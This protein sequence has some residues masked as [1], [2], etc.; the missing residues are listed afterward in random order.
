M[1][2][3]RTADGGPQAERR[4][5]DQLTDWPD[6]RG[7]AEDEL[8]RALDF[9]EVTWVDGWRASINAVHRVVDG[10]WVGDP[11]KQYAY[12][13]VDRLLKEQPRDDGGGGGT[14]SLVGAMRMLAD[15][16]P[17]IIAETDRR[18]L[19]RRTPPSPGR[20]RPAA[21]IYLAMLAVRGVVAYRAEQDE[22]ADELAFYRAEVARLRP[23][24]EQERAEFDPPDP[25][26]D[27]D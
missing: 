20:P 7:G 3:E 9:E 6:V 10:S 2:H 24:A 8:R 22:T 1:N 12:D 4:P 19:N 5:G 25:E 26:L 27:S 18:P 23:L 13:L 11:D 16:L 14:L 15:R 21:G 17:E